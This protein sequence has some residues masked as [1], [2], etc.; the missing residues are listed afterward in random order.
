M[1]LGELA[2]GAK[3]LLLVGETQRKSTSIL[4]DLTDM[5]D[6]KLNPQHGLGDPMRA[7]DLLDLYQ[8]YNLTNSPEDLFK[9]ATSHDMK[10]SAN[11]R[12]S[13]TIFARMADLMND[14][15]KYKHGFTTNHDQL[16]QLTHEII[17]E[18]RYFTMPKYLYLLGHD[19]INL[20]EPEK[21]LAYIEIANR[22]SIQAVKDV[23]VLLEDQKIPL[24]E[25]LQTYAV[26]LQRTLNGSTRP[27]LIEISE[28]ARAID[29]A[30]MQGYLAE[31]P[32]VKARYDRLT[33]EKLEKQYHAEDAKHPVETPLE[34]A[35]SHAASTRIPSFF[36]A[37]SDSLPQ[38]GNDTTPY[39]T[40]TERVPA[41]RVSP[42]LVLQKK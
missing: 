29:R 11:W 5:I 21:T 1:P 36:P 18:K 24:E 19:L 28:K 3:G 15:Y 14:T 7:S 31:H 38:V 6:R 23:R 26:D 25:V 40:V 10:D 35:L 37:Q 41:A 12:L 4:T 8:K 42:E 16:E 22:Y 9:D 30:E 20:K 2:L 39:T 13:N 32:E 33:A 34:P 17:G 27:E